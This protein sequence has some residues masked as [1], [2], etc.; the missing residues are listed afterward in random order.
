MSIIDLKELHQ[1]IKRK[2][3][4]IA[5]VVDGFNKCGDNDLSRYS[6]IFFK[7]ILNIIFK[8]LS[9]NL[10]KVEKINQDTY[11]L[12]DFKSLI[13]FQIT[14]NKQK[15]KRAKTLN[16]Y[17]QKYSQTISEIYV[18]IITTEKYTKL[19][20]EDI[21]YKE[22]NIIE[23]IAIMENKCNSTDLL[24]IRDILFNSFGSDSKPIKKQKEASKPKAISLK[25]FKR[26]RVL[27]K[28]LK[29]ELIY[30]EYYNHFTQEQ[31]YDS[32]FEQ[33]KD[34]RFILRAFDDNEYPEVTDTSKWSR[35]FLYDFYLNGLQIWLSAGRGVNII[36][37]N[38]TEEWFVEYSYE[39]PNILTENQ[40][41]IEH[42]RVIGKLPYTN[43]VDFHDGDEYYNDYH[44]F[45][46][47]IGVEDSPF[48]EIVH[49]VKNSFGFWV[50]LDTKKQ[51]K[52]N[53]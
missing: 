23:L 3:F 36:Y 8:H 39:S 43:I 44:I 12:I 53:A 16:N 41:R 52:T 42:A 51:I 45:C 26:I 34:M 38:I 6:E 25:E 31:L 13:C 49:I 46:K 47:Y 21:R 7:N 37:N 20:S 19:K 9:L 48:E 10:E 27:E 22:L 4:E 5:F 15:V 11:D 2:L 18:L 1:Q 32:P 50:E 30:P 33:F 14:S 35:T 17:K 29:S 40:V 28:K 24:E